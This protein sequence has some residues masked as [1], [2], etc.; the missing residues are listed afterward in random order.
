MTV[1]AR[2]FL[3]LM[4]LLFWQGGFLFYSSVVVPVGQQVLGSHLSQGFITQRVTNYLNLSGAVALVILAV[5]VA[6]A[7]DR[8]SWRRASRWF[9]WLVM[10]ATLGWLVW[11]HSQMDALLD[12]EGQE[13]LDYLAFRIKHRWYLWIITA[14]WAFGLVYAWLTLWAWRAADQQWVG[15]DN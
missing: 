6:V 14:Q 4:V 9:A 11:L 2:R 3:V 10:A 15:S 5:E 1:L 7:P 8:S 12:S 13:I